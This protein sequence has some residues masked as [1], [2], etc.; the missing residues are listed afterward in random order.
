[1]SYIDGDA[2]DFESSKKLK[3]LAF[4]KLSQLSVQIIF[5]IYLP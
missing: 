1:M 2:F 3:K 4:V 5:L